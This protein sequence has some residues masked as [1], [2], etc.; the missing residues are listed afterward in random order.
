MGVLEG[1]NRSRYT[2]TVCDF[3][4]SCY[5]TVATATSGV[6]LAKA[7]PTVQP[8]MMPFSSSERLV[9]GGWAALALCGVAVL[10]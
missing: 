8:T 6:G 7:T 2:T 5:T 4:N 10:L 3:Q 1:A 9:A